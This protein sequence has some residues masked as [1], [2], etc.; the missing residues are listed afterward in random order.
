MGNLPK[1]IVFK[2]AMARALALGLLGL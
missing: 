2:L 1:K